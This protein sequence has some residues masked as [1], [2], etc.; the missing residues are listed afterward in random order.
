M[1]LR[2]AAKAKPATPPV[3]TPAPKPAA[4]AQPRPGG[5][6]SSPAALDL[7]VAEEDSNEAYYARHYQHFEWPQ[8]ASGPTVGIGYDCG[9]VTAAEL[10]ADWSGIVDDATIAALERA[11]GLRGA[12][13]QAF[14]HARGASVTIPW[15]RAIAEFRDREM[16]K[17][18]RHVAAALPNTALLSGD[19]FGALVSLAYNRGA[20]GFSAPGAR[21]AEMRAIKAHMAAKEFAR[22]PGEFL[23]MRRLWPSGGDLWRRRGHEAAL[24][25][26]GLGHTPAA[27]KPAPRS[28]AWLQQSLNTLMN[29]GLAVDDIYGP[30]TRAAVRAFQERV[31]LAV[32]GRAGDKTFSAIEIAML[33]TG[34][35][36]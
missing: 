36:T 20:G 3:P 33:Q 28:A 9:Y 2:A 31:G 12:A 32:D 30:H 29:A 7:I 8:G 35:T 1:P 19:C 10:R 25:E 26:R 4:P 18:E 13:A 6:R 16:P 11:C 27:A 23:S 17:W 15:D 21:Y 5:L 24:F 34:A 14:V 22:I